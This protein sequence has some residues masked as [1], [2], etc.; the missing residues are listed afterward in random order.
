MKSSPLLS[1]NPLYIVDVG[2]RDGMHS[3]WN[4]FT[5]SYK[6]ILFEPDPK[7]YKLLKSKSRENLIILNSALSDST[8]ELD[9]HLCQ[10]P[11][12][13]SAYWPNIDFLNKFP[14]VERFD[15]V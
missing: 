10:K 4:K 2:A 11:G 6:G 14:E 13:S 12:V 7:E 3:R 1:D 5:S 8:G 9:F 15:V